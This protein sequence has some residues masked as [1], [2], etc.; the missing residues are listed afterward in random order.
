MLLVTKSFLS[1]RN[2]NITVS[3]VK[4]GEDRVLKPTHFGDS[5]SD[6]ALFAVL[7]YDSTIQTY[8]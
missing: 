1:L 4:I 5:H 2:F 3:R 8:K 6:S 7:K